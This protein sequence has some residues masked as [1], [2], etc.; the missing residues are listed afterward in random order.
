MMNGEINTFRCTNCSTE[1]STDEQT[2]HRIIEGDANPATIIVGAEELHNIITVLAVETAEIVPPDGYGKT[3][4]MPIDYTELPSVSE[5]DNRDNN[6]FTVDRIDNPSTEQSVEDT[7]RDFETAVENESEYSNVVQDALD[8]LGIDLPF[9]FSHESEDTTKEVDESDTDAGQSVEDASDT[10][11]ADVIEETPVRLDEAI[12]RQLKEE[13]QQVK[14]YGR[15]EADPKDSDMHPSSLYQF[16]VEVPITTEAE[17]AMF[18][19]NECI[20]S[21]QNADKCGK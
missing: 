12:R 6:A 5:T 21:M 8:A 4:T 17:S 13:L 3:E 10:T 19:C 14:K 2:P 16:K 18:L 9:D 15:A 1:Y 20:K 7:L 11:T